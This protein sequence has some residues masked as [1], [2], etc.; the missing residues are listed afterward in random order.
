M[1]ANAIQVDFSRLEGVFSSLQNSVDSQTGL[2]QRLVNNDDARA[3]AEARSNRMSS[4]SRAQTGD[5]PGFK[6]AFGSKAGS[7]IGGGFGLGGLLEA[8]GSSLGKS[9]GA[10]TGI[11]VGIA[12][13]FTALAGAD[14]AIKQLGDGEALMTLMGNVAEGLASFTGPEMIALGGLLGAGAIFGTVAGGGFR[15]AQRMVGA[16][17]G[18][19]A[20]GAGIAGFLTAMSAGDWA[21]QRI[22]ST[23]ENL[24]IISKNIVDSITPFVENG[25]AGGAFAALLATG[26][27]FGAVAGQAPKTGAKAGAGAVFGTAV[28]GAAIASFFTGF[29]AV[30]AIPEKLGTTGYMMPLIA[31]NLYDTVKIFTSGDLTGNVIS[32]LFAAGGVLGATAGASGAY[33]TAL[34]AAVGANFGTFAI[35][36]SIGAFFAGFAAVDWAAD[37]IGADGSGLKTI[38]KNMA[39]AMKVFKDFTWLGPLVAAGGI[40]GAVA[41]GA[42]AATGG[43]SAVVAAGAAVGANM[44]TFAIGAAIG[45]FFAG[46]GAASSAAE[47]LGSDGSQL[48]TIAVNM[49]DSIKQFEGIDATKVSAAGGAMMSLSGG[50]AAFLG[51]KGLGTVAG[52]AE[53]AFNAVKDTFNWIFGRESGQ[54]QTVIEKIISEIQPIADLDETLITKMDTFGEAIG[55]FVG[56]FQDLA[57]IKAEG[58]ATNL[59]SMLTG[60]GA[61]LDA[62]DVLI[63]GGEWDGQRWGWGDNISFGEEGTGG[64]ANLTD[65]NI[66]II[67]D[68]VSKLY[69]AMGFNAQGQNREPPTVSLSEGSTSNL[70]AILAQTAAAAT[71]AAAS[72]AAA[73][74]SAAAAAARAGGT[75]IQNNNTTVSTD[76]RSSLDSYRFNPQ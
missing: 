26:A 14:A 28:M 42:A 47:W 56:S 46:F 4:V 13:F 60:I 34:G 70:E 20:I 66:S 3:A 17:L 10:L 68:G 15:G 23:G 57:N 43:A 36:A 38:A 65:E 6:S 21:I 19:T 49:A 40:F 18:I 45:A 24:P 75:N 52:W 73:A 33:G 64:L 63:N 7:L 74:E 30:G 39:D 32:G 8:A 35:G 22:G 62:K 53:S 41:G 54:P 59:G 25:A 48:K 69:G 72:A 61:L 76:P 51:A 31:Q 9:A 50:I 12:G 16:T 2:L 67:R 1:V 27:I 44:M 5:Q 55:R 11:G 29:A 58:I 37:K 71:A